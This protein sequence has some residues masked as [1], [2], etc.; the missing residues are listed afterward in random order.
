MSICIIFKGDFQYF[1]LIF[2]K[3]RSPGTIFVKITTKVQ[4][5]FL[6]VDKYPALLTDAFSNLHLS[7]QK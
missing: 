2:H 3:A 6:T 1:I 4:L 5:F 7:H